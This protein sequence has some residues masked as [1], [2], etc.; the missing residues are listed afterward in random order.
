MSFVI[1]FHCR[2]IITHIFHTI[3]VLFG[4]NTPAFFNTLPLVKSEFEIVNFRFIKFV[5]L[6][7]VWK[8]DLNPPAPWLRAK[9]IGKEVGGFKLN[10]TVIFLARYTLIICHYSLARGDGGCALI[11]QKVTT[12]GIWPTFV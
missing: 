1:L 8:C 12:L 9:T 10:R 3:T 2:E 4:S 5:L 6:F 11:L 7:D